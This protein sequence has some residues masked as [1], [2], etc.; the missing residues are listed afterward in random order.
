MSELQA[1][2]TTYVAPY[3]KPYYYYDL[4]YRRVR[5]ATMKHMD[6]DLHRYFL[7]N[8]HETARAAE[9]YGEKMEQTREDLE[10]RYDARSK[11][12]RFGLGYEAPATT[13]LIEPTARV[14]HAWREVRK[15]IKR[16]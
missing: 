14:M 10:T 8:M 9:L 15:R 5:S 3:G 4:N 2:I 7:G 16:R 12:E 1:T 6:H 11:L 13:R